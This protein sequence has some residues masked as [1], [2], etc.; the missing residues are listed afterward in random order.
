MANLVRRT[1]ELTGTVQG[2]GF[3][4][5]VMKLAM[6]MGVAGWVRNGG[7]AAE[8]VCE[9]EQSVVDGFLREVRLRL[10]SGATILS[11]SEATEQPQ[12]VVGFSAKE[13]TMVG[14]GLGVVPDRAPC[15]ACLVEMLDPVDRR[16]R[17][18]FVNCTDCGPRWTL[19]VDLPYDRE[20]TSMRHFPLCVDCA[21]EY[22][23]PGSRRFHAEPIACPACGPQLGFLNAA[24]ERLGSGEDAL[25]AARDQ[26]S[27]GKIV[28]MKGVGG[29]QCLCRADDEVV[30]RRLR[31]KKG[32]P[33]KPFALMAE[34]LAQIRRI[35]HISAV[36]QGVLESAVAPIVL[37]RRR[38][39]SLVARSVAPRL[40]HLGVMLPSSPLHHLLML[41]L[42]FPIVATS[43]NLSGEPICITEDD[44]KI[45]LMGRVDGFLV[46]NRDIVR[47]VDD[48]VVQIVGRSVRVIRRARGYAPFTLPTEVGH[49]ACLLGL[50]GHLKNTVALL[51]NSQVVV[52]QFV[53]DLDSVASTA[54][55]RQSAS[56]LVGLTRS[57]P[58][59]VVTDWHPDY[60]T[61]QEAARWPCAPIRVQHH[62]AHVMAAIAEAGLHG[63]V[64][65]VVWDGFGLGENNEL[66]GGEWLYVDRHFVRRVAHLRT[67]ALIGGEK[68][69]VEPWRCA[70]S[71]LAELYGNGWRTIAST[72]LGMV[73]VQHRFDHLERLMQITPEPL[74]SSAAGRLFDAAAALLGCSVSVQ[75]WEG[76]AGAELEATAGSVGTRRAILASGLSGR[77]TKAQVGNRFQPDCDRAHRAGPLGAN[78]RSNNP[79]GGGFDDVREVRPEVVDWS[80]VLSSLVAGIR[81]GRAV[82][83]L[84]SRFHRDLANLIAVTTA[85]FGVKNVVLAGGC[86]QNRLLA[87]HTIRG[88]KLLG[89]RPFLPRL[90][91]PGDSALAV[92]QVVAASIM[93]E[94]QGR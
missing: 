42:G 16:F 41:G 68:A 31:Q 23:D 18:P 81:A 92:G 71:V 15:S 28:A 5:T 66:W 67:L 2:V 36:E 29:F 37:L 12:G 82:E 6:S 83:L 84:A 94:S 1:V 56:D 3:R 32:R 69:H 48:S 65:G 80:L 85:R 90:F 27:A 62:H 20:R 88:L 19:V 33:D 70:V 24:G 58:D 49:T 86:F 64:I 54:V 79:I 43:G 57:R 60:R 61:T 45:K 11:W 75:S 77:N 91:P 38:V 17:Y 73:D 63:P 55:H 22:R 34:N 7:G 35:C 9:G 44:A 50:G 21:A 47:P 72:I 89:M 25:L 46:H 74:R 14:A 30:V 87:H 8:I 78:F 59:F 4:P 76:Q 13:S 51:R 52:G 53:G 93:L 39:G 40:R 10:P 26:L